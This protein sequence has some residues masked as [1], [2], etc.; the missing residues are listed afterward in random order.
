M[1]TIL[2]HYFL[3]LWI[4]FQCTEYYILAITTNKPVSSYT[5]CLNILHIYVKIIITESRLLSDLAYTVL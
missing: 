5:T 2:P 4:S 3:K 1:K